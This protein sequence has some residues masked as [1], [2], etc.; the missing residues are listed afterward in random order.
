[1]KNLKTLLTMAI[2]ALM[3]PV[4]HLAMRTLTLAILYMAL[5]KAIWILD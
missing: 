1:M 3:S 4:S 2:V 5:G